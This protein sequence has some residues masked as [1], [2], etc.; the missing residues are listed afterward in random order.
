MLRPPFPERF[1][2]DGDFRPSTMLEC[3]ENF[4]DPRVTGRCTHELL[5]IIAIVLCAT[6]VGADDFESMADFAIGRESWFRERLGLKL[7]HGIPSH[8]TLNRVMAMLDPKGFGERFACLVA[9]V[10]SRIPGADP[11]PIAIDG[12]AMRGTKK[13]G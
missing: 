3:F 12:K 4:P 2:S 13:T 5:E 9:L 7:V 1:M 6:I 10:A 11:E 8:D